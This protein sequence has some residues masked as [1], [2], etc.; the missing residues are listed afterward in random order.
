MIITHVKFL[1]AEVEKFSLKDPVQIKIHF[2]DGNNKMITLK[3]PLANIEDEAHKAVLAVRAYMKEIN[4]D[5]TGYPADNF[6][7]NFV[8]V[9]IE[10]EDK[11]E[12]KMKGFFRKI[13]EK[14]HQL[15]GSRMHSGYLDMVNQG[16][17]LNIEF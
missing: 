5:T 2:S 14:K 8:N 7:D 13:H 17:N 3:V 1:K 4:Q 9:V 15:G 6:L 16:R 11:V 10:D 12:E